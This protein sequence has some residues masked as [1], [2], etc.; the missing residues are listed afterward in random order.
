MLNETPGS[1]DP[2][3][4]PRPPRIALIAVHGVADQHPGDTAK[5]LAQQLSA[6]SQ[7]DA[8]A[9]RYTAW[10]HEPL[11]IAV[12]PVPPAPFETPDMTEKPCP[13]YP[14]SLHSE[15]ALQYFG[16]RETRQP[17]L[18]FMSK[19]LSG[20]RGD[21][22]NQSYGVTRLS[23][24]RLDANGHVTA[25]VDVFE[26][27]WADLSRLGTGVLRILGEFYQL[28]FHLTILGRL[29]VDL[30]RSTVV[31]GFCRWL[32]P[33]FWVSELQ[34]MASWLLSVPIALLNFILILFATVALPLAVPH[35]WRPAAAAVIY[36]ALV[37]LLV[38]A[39]RLRRNFEWGSAWGAL[40]GVATAALLYGWFCWATDN[41]V[42]LRFGATQALAL[43]WC[44][45][46]AAV[47]ALLARALGRQI[48]I[49]RRF[50]CL[51]A[52][53]VT[54]AFAANMLFMSALNTRD[55]VMLAAMR[56]VD[57]IF[58]VLLLLWVILVGLHFLAWWSGALAWVTAEPAERRA[59]RTGRIGMAVPTSLFLIVT[60]AVWAMLKGT[61]VSVL[62]AVDYR[63]WSDDISVIPLSPS[64]YFDRLLELSA[65]AGFDI[66]LMLIVAGGLCMLV[67]VMPSL[68]AELSPPEPVDES[69]SRGLG[70]WLDNGIVWGTIGIG[71]L[72]FAVVFWIPFATEFLDWFPALKAFGGHTT[73]IVLAG[74]LTG[75]AVGIIALSRYSD[76]LLKGV[77]SVLDIAL[78]VD[79]WL[80]EQPNQRTPT[81]RICAR[82]ASL[83][84]HIIQWRGADGRGY[85]GIVIVSHSQGTV[86]TTELLRFIR[87]DYVEPGDVLNQ[88]GRQ[89]PVRLM[90]VGSPLRQLYSRRFPHLYA[91]AAMP[92][93]AETGVTRWTNAYFSGDYVGRYLWRGDAGARNWNPVQEGWVPGTPHPD[94][95]VYADGRTEFCLGAGAHTHYFDGTSR[96]VARATDELVAAGRG[97]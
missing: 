48:P 89:M 14:A 18:E 23:A 44:L 92:D 43:V 20:Y 6:L 72:V 39:Y 16:A 90:T 7:F 3:A 60:L 75:S 28:L 22:E 57:G 93:L 29:T 91:W 4:A 56:V 17:A 67:A 32:Q 71:I 73:L 8:Q 2:S 26:M 42:A 40:T 66:L 64:E 10:S 51:L 21:K 46:I 11:S 54:L 30:A 52:A 1:T 58:A 38:A 68:A 94:V 36:G 79:Q 59:I 80:R 47:T 15:F 50:G 96:L 19:K 85:D 74:L 34:A 55:H 61:I 82:Y 88:V 33:W 53:L 37:G 49:A 87:A 77:R 9:A 45:A 97:I 69:R 76:A 25:E 63:P 24:Q 86:I 31:T 12:A 5:D 78:D 41:A 35:D 13:G 84:R 65:G 70:R 83:L 62:P 27:Y 81:A 95:D